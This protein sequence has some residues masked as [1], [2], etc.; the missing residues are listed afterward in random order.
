MPE[1]VEVVQVGDYARYVMVV[2]FNQRLIVVDDRSSVSVR[3]VW[4][5]H[6]A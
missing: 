2:D 4:N 5:T 6:C 3:R 1:V